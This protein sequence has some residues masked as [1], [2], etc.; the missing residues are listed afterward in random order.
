MDLKQ[1]IEILEKNKTFKLIL[2]T[3][4][5]VGNF[6][7]GAEVSCY[8]W[9][10]LLC[11]IVSILFIYSKVKGFQIEY[12][13]KVPEVKDTVH[14]HSL[15][16]HLCHMIME[17][18]SETTD[19]YS[20]I[21]PVTRAS[22]VDFDELSSN[23]SKMEEDCKA[24]WDHLRAIAK[25]DG[26]TNVKIKYSFI[27]WIWYLDNNY[28][29]RWCNSWFGSDNIDVLL[30]LFSGCQ[31]SLPIV[32]RESWSQQ[33]FTDVLWIG[34]INNFL[35]KVF[36]KKLQ[37]I[38]SLQI[39]EISFMARHSAG[40]SPWNEARPFLQNRFWI[41]FRIPHYT[42]SGTATA[43]KESNTPRTK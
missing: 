35:V 20:E 31:N 10:K 13:A 18:N 11:C 41:R 43:W 5:A 24:S 4:L 19:L 27:P 28:N 26:N 37:Y 30:W 39:P 34:N 21:G 8:D 9:F 40:R 7:N 22:R 36:P 25:H 42:W 3:L 38:A 15:L 14:K 29:S 33:S 16:H 17:Q 12:L 2:A 1:G 6:L 23:L 32:P